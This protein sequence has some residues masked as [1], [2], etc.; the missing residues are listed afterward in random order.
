ML[1]VEKSR[2]IN[3]PIEEVF[4]YTID[5][6]HAPE[7]YTGA[8]AISDVQRLPNG[9]YSFKGDFKLAGLHTEVTGEN[10]EFVPNERLVTQARSALDDLTIAVTFERVERDKT[11]VTCH[12]EH[13]LHGGIL[14]K[15]GEAFL[16]S[17]FDH[18]A[19]LTQLNLKARIETQALA[20]TP[21]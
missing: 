2:V 6:M 20:A 16:A 14:G 7:Y 12:E 17:Y 5:P 10:V 19:E 13:T 8:Q 1:T 3:A 11:R 15:L 18:A 4:A 21:S 9:G